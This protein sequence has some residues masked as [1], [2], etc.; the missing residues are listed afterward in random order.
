MDT[1]SIAKNGEQHKA[2]SGQAEKWRRKRV[3]LTRQGGKRSEAREA[4]AS[5]A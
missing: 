4:R 1:K 2:S 3:S 5:E